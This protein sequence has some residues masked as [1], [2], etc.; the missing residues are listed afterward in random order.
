MRIIAGDFKGRKLIPPKN[1]RIRPTADRVK[2]AIF[3]MISFRVFDSLVL[4]LFAGTGNLGLEALSRGAQH[5]TFVEKSVDSI[6]ILNQN[7]KLLG[8]VEKTEVIR[9]DAINVLSKLNGAQ[10]AY[11]IV[12]IDPPYREKLYQKILSTIVKYD[13]IKDEGLVIVEHPIDTDINQV[14]PPLIPI[15]EKRYGKTAVSIFTKGG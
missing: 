10:T 5:V 1:D 13:I 7:I 4:D 15:N 2:E 11:D 12:F 9:G 3:S 8:Q 14:C 6:K